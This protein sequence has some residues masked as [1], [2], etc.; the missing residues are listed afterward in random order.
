MKKGMGYFSPMRYSELPRF[1]RENLAPVDVVMLQVSPMDA[2][3]NF[4]FGLAASHLA[5]MMARAKCIIVEVNQNMPW[6]YG[7]TGTEINIQDVTYVVEGDNPPWLSWAQAASLPT[8]TGPWPTWWYP[9]SPTGPASSW[10]SAACPT[11]SAP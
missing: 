1:Y 3:G 4:N 6:V 5:D 10:A 9:R 2:H 8:W 7:L 11:P